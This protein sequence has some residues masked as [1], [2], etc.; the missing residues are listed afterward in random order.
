MPPPLD[1]A[2][3]LSTVTGSVTVGV[4]A[5]RPRALRPRV[6]PRA[7]SSS[8]GTPTGAG[9]DVR[10]RISARKARIR[11]GSVIR[12]PSPGVPAVPPPEPTQG[13]ISLP[14]R[15]PHPPPPTGPGADGVP[16]LPGVPGVPGAPGGTARTITP[17]EHR[18]PYRHASTT[19]MAPK[20]PQFVRYVSKPSKRPSA[21]VPDCSS[22]GTKSV[23]TSADSPADATRAVSASRPESRFRSKWCPCEKRARLSRI[24]DVIGAP[25]ASGSVE[26]TRNRPR[27]P[28]V[29]IRFD[30]PPPVEYIEYME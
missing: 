26:T 2:G 8:L 7:T 27:R 29:A 28:K 25:T 21:K 22:M 17:D 24:C 1:G 11:S 6:T 30:H 23:A 14:Y 4:D 13:T 18:A 12:V 5:S 19:R 3:K 10:S 15:S 20:R 16:G 9:E